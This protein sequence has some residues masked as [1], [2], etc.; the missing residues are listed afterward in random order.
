MAQVTAPR[1]SLCTVTTAPVITRG[2][3][4][5]LLF[6]RVQEQMKSSQPSSLYSTGKA[7]R[8]KR[9]GGVSVFLHIAPPAVSWK[10]LVSAELTA[11][12]IPVRIHF[13]ASKSTL[14]N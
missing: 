14:N 3:L 10:H 2:L 12:R 1:L 8:A 7:E 6:H 9:R 11:L 5:S 4:G 13:I